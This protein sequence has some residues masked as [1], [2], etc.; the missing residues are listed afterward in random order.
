MASNKTDFWLD[1]AF[2]LLYC[3]LSPIAFGFFCPEENGGDGEVILLLLM[4]ITGITLFIS[5]A[6]TYF[7]RQEFHCKW[8]N[9]LIGFIPLIISFVTFYTLFGDSDQFIKSTFLKS[10][11]CEIALLYT[12]RKLL[13]T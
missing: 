4:I 6:L 1:M 11:F 9:L 13:L 8:M 7:A 2:L 10:N 12:A 5:A 3:I